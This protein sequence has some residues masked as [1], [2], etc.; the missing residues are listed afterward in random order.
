MPHIQKA[1]LV[2]CS[3]GLPANRT[4]DVLQLCSVLRSC[5]IQPVPGEHLFRR[6]GFSSGTPRE[7]ADEL[8]R[9]FKDDSIDAIFDLSGGDLANEIL[10]FLDFDMIASSD[11]EFWGYSDITCV[12]NAICTKTGKPGVLYSVNNLIRSCGDYQQNQFSQ[13]NHME[14]DEL[15]SVPVRFL[16]GCEME[17]IVVGGNLRCLLKLAGTP[18]FPNLS[19]KLLLLESLG[20]GADRMAA[21]IAQLE[22]MGAFEKIAGLLLGTFTQMEQENGP[23]SMEKL[24]LNRVP[25]SLPVAKTDWIGHGPDAH[26]IRIGTFSHF[27]A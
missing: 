11:K 5:G 9:F 23:Y 24:I 14:S 10:H 17:G 8:I 22:Q 26:A 1:G 4:T 6:D 21:F 13:Y 12:L 27:K 3:N 20:G 7:R 25:A 15:F 2:C 19:D 16:Q 18:Y